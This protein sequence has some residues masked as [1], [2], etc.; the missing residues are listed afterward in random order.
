M[1]G[2]AALLVAMALVPA[3]EHT[4]NVNI[5]LALVI[6]VIAA[7]GIGG[8]QAGLVTAL[9]AALAFDF[10]FTQPYLSLKID[11]AAD[12]QT[13]VL[14]LV[15]GLVAG[16][17]AARSRRPKATKRSNLD[18][19]RRLQRVTDLA[20]RGDSPDDLVL[21]VQAEL[22]ET[23]QLVDCRFERPPF[24]GAYPELTSTGG[25]VGPVTW[26]APDGLSLPSE[27][28][29][30]PVIAGDELYGRYVLVPTPGLVTPLDRRLIATALVGQ[31][32]VALVARPAA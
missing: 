17:I 25:L 8:S 31:L 2:L 18:E 30:I 32:R 28:I 4:A 22:I 15:V 3:R 26:R 6:V 7:A 16:Q 12:V 24:V 14:L 13:T 20:A 23:L 5:A 10:F 1:G 27:G 29:T 19:L 9:T 21:E 11:D